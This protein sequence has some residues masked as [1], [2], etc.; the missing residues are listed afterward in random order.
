M[1][2]PLAGRDRLVAAGSSACCGPGVARR[3]NSRD[4]YSCWAG[5]RAEGAA[6]GT[7]A[8]RLSPPPRLH[9]ANQAPPSRIRMAIALGAE[10]PRPSGA[11]KVNQR[12]G[13]SD[14][15][16]IPDRRRVTQLFNAT[17]RTVPADRHR[18][19]GPKDHA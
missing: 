4:P 2:F 7:H 1:Q 16:W 6:A 12:A 14:R 5:V 15:R 19:G 13:S 11:S 9:T 8:S 18:W 3:A 17:R 10:S